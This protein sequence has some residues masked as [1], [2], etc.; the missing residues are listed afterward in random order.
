[1]DMLESDILCLLWGTDWLLG[2][3]NWEHNKSGR[4]KDMKKLSRALGSLTGLTAKIGV[5]GQIKR[6]GLRKHSGPEVLKV[7]S[8]GQQNQQ[9][10]GIY[11]KCILLGQ[12]LLNQKSWE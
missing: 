1:M 4:K 5:S 8:L 2:S 10:L 7:W 9:C 6:H 11:E 12:I 3:V